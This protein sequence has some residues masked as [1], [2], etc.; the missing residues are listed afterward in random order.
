LF[1]FFRVVSFVCAEWAQ[2]NEGWL[3]VTAV[4][5]IILLAL[6]YFCV[7]YAYLGLVG[8]RRVFSVRNVII[9]GQSYTSF[10]LVWREEAVFV[11]LFCVRKA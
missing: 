4:P 7:R 2:T 3:E 5:C 10:L 11:F 8:Q 1:C 6:S 9:T